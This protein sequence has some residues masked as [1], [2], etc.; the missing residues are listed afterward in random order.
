MIILAL[1]LRSVSSTS[2]T[3]TG[4]TNHFLSYSLPLSEEDWRESLPTKLRDK[5]GAPLHR[6]VARSKAGNETVTIYL[7]GTSHVSRNSCLDAEL[8]MEYV[9]PDCLFVELCSQ[10]VGLMLPQ[11]ESI[12]DDGDQ[13]RNQIRM[14]SMSQR[15]ANMFAKIQNDYASKL[16]VTIGGE[17]KTAFRSALRQQR[18]FWDSRQQYQIRA[19][20]DIGHPRANRPCA[21]V[22]GDRPVRITLMRAWESLRFFGKIKLVFALLWSSTIKQPSE[23]ELLEWMESILNDRTGNNDLMK[24]AM[25]EMAK[26]FPSLKRVIID[27]RDDFMVAKL[28]QTAEL[29]ACSS[30]NHGERILVAVIGAGHCNGVVKKLL[31]TT[32]SQRPEDTLSTITRTKRI[33]DDDFEGSEVVQFDYAY[34]IETGMI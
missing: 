15:S 18:E 12:H 29:L 20:N 1:F 8:L 5:K 3:S 10:R 24:K 28:K 7:L 19:H 11:P 26:S 31:D 32:S 33:A 25:D 21:I 6:L 27:E 17:F 2:Q 13:T 30:N 23:K 4:I 9:R 34:A 16:N 22:L 14:S